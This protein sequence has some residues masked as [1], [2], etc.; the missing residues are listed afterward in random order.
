M[1]KIIA[2]LNLRALNFVIN[3]YFKTRIA[4]IPKTAQ[5]HAVRA[6]DNDN[7][8]IERIN[9]EIK[10]HFCHCLNA[11]FFDRTNKPNERGNEA[12]MKFEYAPGFPKAPTILKYSLLFSIIPK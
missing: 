4:E 12:T 7:T 1:P 10:M 11:D 6:C 8:M 9:V 3:P 5:I 2:H